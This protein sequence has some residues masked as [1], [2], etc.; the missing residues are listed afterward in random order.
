MV[1]PV[2]FD[3]CRYR[4]H[5]LRFAFQSLHEIAV[6]IKQH[7]GESLCLI[8]ASRYREQFRQF[9]RTEKPPCGADINEGDHGHAL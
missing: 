4:I 9:L 3:L 7:S 5:D 8:I 6:G 2:A 1:T